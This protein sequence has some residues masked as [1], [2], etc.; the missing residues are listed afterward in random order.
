MQKA[1]F[2]TGFNNWGKTRI[3]ET[4]FNRRRFFHGWHYGIPGIN[5]RFTVE[6]HSNDDYWGWEWSKMVTKRL[7][8]ETEPDLNLFTAL[9]PTMHDNNR[10][11]DLL[12]QPPFDRYQELHVLLVEYKFEHHAKLIIDHILAAGAVVPNIHFTVINADA[13]LTIDADRFDAK[14]A[15]IRQALRT[16][17]P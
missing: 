13:T 10:F 2:I 12:L 15:Q 5:A 16:I 3:I 7:N 14:M 6:S 1:V 9:C 4:L 11:T 8:N 17:F